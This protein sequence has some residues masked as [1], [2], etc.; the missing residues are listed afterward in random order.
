MSSIHSN[1]GAMQHVFVFVFF[2]K[3]Q[4][5]SP[6]AELKT[7]ARWT[8]V[9]TRTAL[10]SLHTGSVC[11]CQCKWTN[12]QRQTNVSFTA[13]FGD[14]FER[15]HLLPLLIHTSNTSTSLLLQKVQCVKLCHRVV[16]S[17]TAELVSSREPWR[18]SPVCL[19]SSG[20]FQAMTHHFCQN[21]FHQNGLTCD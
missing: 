20:H 14:I 10:D 11:I 13:S 21:T 3:N 18:F 17:Q 15:P 2:K 5:S 19:V 9:A 16:S 8:T 1:R 6:H 4:A 7:C 12:L